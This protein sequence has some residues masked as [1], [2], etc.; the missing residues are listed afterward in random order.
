MDS[1]GWVDSRVCPSRVYP[2]LIETG[3][4]SVT[5]QIHTS[6]QSFTDQFTD[7]SRDTPHP[8]SQK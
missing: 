6:I 4:R 2:P 8:L 5:V 7:S 1:G 3:V